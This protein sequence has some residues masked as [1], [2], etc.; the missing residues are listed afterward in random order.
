MFKIRINEF[1]GISRNKLWQEWLRTQAP[2]LYDQLIA[3]VSDPAGGCKKNT[4]VMVDIYNTLVRR[5]K[6]SELTNYLRKEFP[7]ALEEVQKN[8]FKTG[9]KK[10]NTEVDLEAY[11]DLQGPN[12]HKVFK[13][14]NPNI[15]SFPQK[16]IITDP[17]LINLNK[18][19]KSFIKDKVDPDYIII[20]DRAYI[21]YF[22]PKYRHEAAK[23][24]TELRELFQ[25][26]KNNM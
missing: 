20:E 19:I 13:S 8:V 21:E 11:K 15:L 26:R 23:Y 2:D 12:K 17:N 3:V 22:L 14:Y 5:G 6:E 10:T 18:R 9:I 16:K 1:C 7:V 4:A 25:W 24:P